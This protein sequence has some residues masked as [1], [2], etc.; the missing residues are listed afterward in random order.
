MNENS[1]IVKALAGAVLFVLLCSGQA[2]ATGEVLFLSINSAMPGTTTTATVGIGN[3]S[4][5]ESF[6]LELNFN[7]GNT[8]SLPSTNWFTR[9]GYFPS[10]LFAT[11]TNDL[12]DIRVTTSGNKIFIN[13]FNPAGS[14]GFI[15]AVTFKVNSYAFVGIPPYDS[16]EKMPDTQVVTLSGKYLSKSTQQVITLLP[17]TKMFSVGAPLPTYALSVAKAGLGTVEAN[18]GNITWSGDNGSLSVVSDSMI[19]LTATPEANYIF[20]GWA[21]ACDGTGACAVTMDQAKSVTATFSLIQGNGACGTAD[22]KDFAAPPTENLCS[23]GTIEQLPSGPGPWEWICKGSNGGS[24]ASCSAGLLATAPVPIG[25]NVIVTP[26]SAVSLAF[27]SVVDSGEVQ[28]TSIASPGAK[29]TVDDGTE[30]GTVPGTSYDITSTAGTNGPIT[31]CL[32]YNPANFTVSETSLRLLHYN[33]AT[34]DDITTSV[35]TINDRVCGQTTT[36]SP[37]VIGYQ[38]A[39]I[40]GDCDSNGQV[41]IAEVQGAINMY[42][43]LKPAESCVDTDNSGNTSIAEVQKVINE[44]L[45]L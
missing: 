20:T 23:S 13:G 41:S 30:F 44:Y 7:S 32:A 25:T 34:W 6:S 15:G 28:V 10:N 27:S 21:G 42:L 5:I 19:T 11:T 9:S 29:V 14:S 33:D 43:G 45:G 3:V 16:P 12:N 31:V 36:L 1:G 8:L 24:D 37:F 17:A 35:D 39:N 38:L 22:G 18:A 4:D 26:T 2:I 40:P